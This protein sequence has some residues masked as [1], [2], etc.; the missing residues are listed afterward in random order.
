M[1]FGITKKGDDMIK[2]T[3]YHDIS[4]GHR[5]YQNKG[6]CGHL[7]GHNYRIWF[8]L[9]LKID[10]DDA[11]MVIDFGIIKKVLCKW[12]EENLDHCFMVYHRDDS[13]DLL[14]NID[15][16]VIRAS[17]NP[18]AENIARWLGDEICPILLA[19]K[20]TSTVEVTKVIVEETRKCSA[21]W[22][23]SK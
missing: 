18:T 11:D 15:E 7:H 5:L 17:F 14:R 23:K 16:K 1:Y 3:R 4:M 9:S 12:L 13:A 8:E 10:D 22:E 6:P 19:S 21:T 20:V 2:A